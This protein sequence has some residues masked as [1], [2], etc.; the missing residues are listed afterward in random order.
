MPSL[1]L[2]S[3]CEGGKCGLEYLFRAGGGHIG[4][5]V[6]PR[7]VPQ[8]TEIVSGNAAPWQRN[9]G[10]GETGGH[11]G[12]ARDRGRPRGDRR[13]RS[14]RWPGPGVG[15][16][17]FPC[18]QPLARPAA[19]AAATGSSDSA[20]ASARFG[21]AVPPKVGDRSPGGMRPPNGKSLSFQPP[22]GAGPIGG[23][24]SPRTACSFQFMVEA[25]IDHG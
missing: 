2:G 9:G 22:P 25:Y 6:R 4:S 24:F 21:A 17:R 1:D 18:P 10:P 20:A 23:G 19:M 16:R 8:G 3:T 13:R 14:P 11:D 5:I 12:S 7:L 15:H